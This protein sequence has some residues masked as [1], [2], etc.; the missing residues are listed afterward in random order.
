MSYFSYPNP[1]CNPNLARRLQGLLGMVVSDSMAEAFEGLVTALEE[2]DQGGMSHL[3]VLECE[4]RLDE[5]L[6]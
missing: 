2:I 1:Y 5:V 6:T 4:A 3:G